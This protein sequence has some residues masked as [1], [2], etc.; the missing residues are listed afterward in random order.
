MVVPERPP[1]RTDSGTFRIRA[2]ISC[3]SNASRPTRGGG[4]TDRTISHPMT[5]SDVVIDPVCGMTI[6]T[7]QSPCSREHEGATYHFCSI[8]C[9]LRFE[10]D[11]PAYVAVSRL[12][13]PGWGL[14]PHPP[15]I[16]ERFRPSAE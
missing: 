11:A 3:K 9:A 15:A 8:E 7:A 4:W 16:T 1:D 14:T 5:L 2:V 10:A 6:T 12:D 13:L